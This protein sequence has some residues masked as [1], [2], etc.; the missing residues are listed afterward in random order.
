[1]PPHRSAPPDKAS[2]WI[3]SR[4]PPQLSFA[5]SC[6]H[7]EVWPVEGS[8]A[9]TTRPE[10]TVGSRCADQN[11]CPQQCHRWLNCGCP[12]R[13]KY[14]IVVV[15]DAGESHAADNYAALNGSWREPFHPN[16]QSK[17]SVPQ[18]NTQHNAPPSPNRKH[19]ILRATHRVVALARDRTV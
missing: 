19:T 3:R 4:G 17:N 16:I 9:T 6:K 13:A 2:H 8:Q 14:S 15:H 18:T 12:D 1:M 7:Q 11:P 10:P 5:W